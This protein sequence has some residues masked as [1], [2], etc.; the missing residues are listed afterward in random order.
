MGHL[1][2]F[3]ELRKRAKFTFYTSAELK[4]GQ[5]QKEGISLCS[6]TYML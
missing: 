2:Q 5:I 3:A 1:T 4:V 6:L